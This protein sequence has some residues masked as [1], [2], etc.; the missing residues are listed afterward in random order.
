MARSKLALPRKLGRSPGVRFARRRGLAGMVFLLTAALA[1]P[2]WAQVH[3]CDGGQIV[4]DNPSFDYCSAFRQ[5]L[6]P[7][8]GNAIDR[9]LETILKNDGT[10]KGKLR[11]Y[12][13]LVSVSKYPNLQ[14][15]E[16][17]VLKGVADELAPIVDFLKAQG[18]DEIV[19]L[20]EQ[21]ASPE[22]INYFLTDY[23]KQAFRDRKD[24][25]LLTRFLFAY[26]GHGMPA[27]D[28]ATHGALALSDATSD[29]DFDSEAQVS[30]G[31]SEHAI[32]RSGRS[33]LSNACPCRLLFLRRIVPTVSTRHWRRLL[34]SSRT[35]R[36]CHHRRPEQSTGLDCPRRQRYSVFQ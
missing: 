13:F 4:K 29:D 23:F 25:K 34:L 35:R 22:N 16:D 24:D 7:E 21:Q 20:T 15:P 12:A 33:F 14:N 28:E 19:V 11:S 3:R 9:E 32:E 6:K 36:P 17:Q 30:L 8:Q 18:F 31:R 26:D 2:A 1:H 5:Y 10:L 27:I